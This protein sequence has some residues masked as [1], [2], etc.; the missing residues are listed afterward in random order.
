MDNVKYFEDLSKSIPYCRKIV[1]LL[2]LIRSDKDLLKQGGFLKNDINCLS[3]EFENIKSE[4]NKE[5]LNY[6]KNEEESVIERF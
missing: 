4:Q 3:K 2:F 6:I 1:L 5:Y